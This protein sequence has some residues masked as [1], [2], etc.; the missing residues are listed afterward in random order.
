MSKDRS[1][2]QGESPEDLMLR[3]GSAAFD[4][5]RKR[6]RAAAHEAI[7]DGARG[8]ASIMVGRTIKAARPVAE[9]MQEAASIG[10]ALL[11][12]IFGIDDDEYPPDDGT[13]TPGGS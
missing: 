2:G 1:E 11:D 12:D 8:L 9:G 6:L 3:E 13:P 4:K 7:D 5:V 10:K